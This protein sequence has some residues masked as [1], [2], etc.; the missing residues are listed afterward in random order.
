MHINFR[1]TCSVSFIAI[2]A[3]TLAA[4]GSN[5]TRDSGSSGGLNGG[6]VDA[7]STAT[8]TVD[9]DGEQID[10]NSIAGRAPTARIIYFDFDTSEVRPEYLDVIVAH[11]RYLAQNPNGRVRLEGHTDERGTREYN[12]ALGENRAQAIAGMLQLQGVSSA[13]VRSV[14][15]GEELPVDENHSPDAWAQNRRVQI[16]YENTPVPN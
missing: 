13:Q 12:V 9:A 3:L 10:P 2:A 8:I 11:G 6:G 4:C 15:Y 5:P 16:I 1:K 14:S 7:R